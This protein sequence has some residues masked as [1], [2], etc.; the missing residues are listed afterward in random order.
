MTTTV[1]Y[2]A[3]SY[4]KEK[5]TS[6]DLHH[7]IPYTPIS[8]AVII[9]TAIMPLVFNLSKKFALLVLSILG[10]GLFFALET[11]FEQIP[12]FIIE[13]PQSTNVIGWQTTL[14]IVTPE[15]ER[16][17]LNAQGMQIIPSIKV[18]FQIISILMVLAVIGI[19]YGFYKMAYMNNHEKR[20]PLIAQLITV[21][22][23][24]GLCVLASS[25]S[26]F[27]TGSIYLSS[28]SAFL[29]TTFLILFGVT[30]GIYAGT[31][32]YGKRKLLSIYIPSIIAMLMTTAR[33]ISEFIMFNSGMFR[34]GRGY[35]FEPLGF[36]RLS[37]FDVLTIAIS[38]VVTFLVLKA[39]NRKPLEKG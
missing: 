26:F 13:S 3:L 38:G 32:L 25:T 12:V 9:C 27:R 37:L 19:I 24:I 10:I 33:Y 16:P 11:Y 29:M 17:V 7:M 21:T 8:I 28:T 34:R 2:A 20:K 39:I 23:F 5:R 1:R 6:N 35:L 31:W 15:I 36:L 22:C 30:G 18:H 14:C 4:R